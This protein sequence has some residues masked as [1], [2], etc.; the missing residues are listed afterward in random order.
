MGIFSNL[1]SKGPSGPEQDGQM[2]EVRELYPGG[3]PDHGVEDE[4]VDEFETRRAAFT[5]HQGS[6][7][8]SSEDAP[9]QQDAR[10]SDPEWLRKLSQRASAVL[11]EDQDYDD[12]SA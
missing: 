9:I 3:I 1:R 7:E 10:D 4:D 12:L 11:G 5:V 8:G 6:G 2:A